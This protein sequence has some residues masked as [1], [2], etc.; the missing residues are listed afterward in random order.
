MKNAYDIINDPFLNK[1]T[2]FSAEERELFKLNGMIPDKI[3]TIEEQAAQAYQ[4]MSMKTND[5]DKR[6]FLMKVF[7]HNRTLFYYLF[8]QHVEDFLPIVYDPCIA[9]TI[10]NYS[11]YYTTPQNSAF[12]S[13][14]N[15]ENMEDALKNAA[16]GRDI[17]LIVVTDAEAILG[18]GDWG[19]NGVAISIGKLMVYTAA[20]GLDPQ[21]VLPVVLDVGTNR[22]ELLDDP[23]YLGN[24]HKRVS[25]EPYY[26]FVDQF[27]QTVE[28]L[29]PNLYLHFED[30]GRQCS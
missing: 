1:G 18:I 9:D 26:K 20:A 29:F 16:Y 11:E 3:Q 21:R 24:K 8:S 7:S 17:N 23:L 27:V 19:L 14:D 10:R 25:G 15:P 30:F 12:L 4:A 22:Q 6:H 5:V 2:A 13:I 28:K